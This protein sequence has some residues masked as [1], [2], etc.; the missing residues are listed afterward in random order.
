MKR[1]E[2][3]EHDNESYKR[4]CRETN[5]L[6]QE[7]RELKKVIQMLKKEKYY[8]IPLITACS[9]IGFTA[10]GGFKMQSKQD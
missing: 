1:F 9:F 8:W 6:Y 5:K 7:N 10:G 4:I 2:Y 3:L